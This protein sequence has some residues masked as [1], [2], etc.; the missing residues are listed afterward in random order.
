MISIKT[1][2][3]DETRNVGTMLG[4]IL[5]KGDVVGLEGELGVGKTVLVKGMAAA[6]GVKEYVTSPTFVILNEY[7]GRLPVYHFDVYRVP[8]PGD[9]Y[10]IGFDEYIY[11][12]GIV[13]VE[14][15]DLIRDIL[16]A[17]I[18]WIKIERSC[19]K[20]NIAGKTSNM[21]QN[22][23]FGEA[24]GVG[25]VRVLHMSFTG[26]RYKEYENYLVSKIGKEVTRKEVDKE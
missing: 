11:S 14:W 9:V 6:L 24:G 21:A 17:E 3:E 10:D 26:E 5:R 18:I 23:L 16:P 19:R 2:S 13:I 12:D 20:R 7:K 4:S 15:A 25:G 1:V 22:R 8:G